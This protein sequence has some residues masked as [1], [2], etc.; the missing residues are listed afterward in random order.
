MYNLFDQLQ[1]LF[2]DN[3]QWNY[4]HMTN[5]INP[6]NSP[7]YDNSKRFIK[8][9]LEYSNKTKDIYDVLEL[10]EPYRNLHIVTDYFLGIF[11][12][13]NSYKV[14][15][16]IDNQIK[17]IVSP[18]NISVD[19]T[20]KYFWFLICFYHDVG[21]Y[22]EN[23]S[24]LISSLAN[25][26]IQLRIKHK[27]PRLLGVPKL[28]HSVKNN[29]LLYRYE[30]CNRFD[31]GIIG[32]ILL[33]DRLIKIY[34]YFQNSYYN[35]QKSF[36]HNGLY[37]SDSMFKYFQLIASI[38]L[39]HNMWFKIE[40]V[41]SVDDINI[42]RHYKLDKLVIT[43]S[44]PKINLNKHPFLFLLSLVDTLEPTK[45]QSDPNDPTKRYGV[46][47]L[48]KIKLILP[49]HDSKILVRGHINDKQV[50]DWL[51]SICSL[52]DWIRV[53]LNIYHNSD[54]DIIL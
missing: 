7:A 22:Y 35:G 18:E 33:Y 14:K 39:T 26:E 30:N 25:L 3:R 9:F 5:L 41:D 40:N 36:T 43:N 4:Y 42:Y 47:F 23:N 16:S 53:E 1:K 32:G 12:Y 17:K 6:F 29:Y 28:Y 21:Y 52:K 37:W 15:R 48:K 51:N 45:Q 46:D 44:K 38:I 10:I 20:F 8:E 24:N 54:M 2:N 49:D 19:N 11:I 34:K 27:I 50:T 13:E 31:H